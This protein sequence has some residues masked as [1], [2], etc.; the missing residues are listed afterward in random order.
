M[1][2]RAPL[3]PLGNLYSTPGALAVLSHEDIARA[4]TRHQF[5]DWG[6]VCPED[7][8]TNDESLQTGARLFSVYRG[9]ND[10]K[11]WIITE[12]DRS[13]TTVLLPEEY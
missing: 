3:F 11:F 8:Q 1:S 5:G 9:Q 4:I 13:A 10:A 2:S 12:S 6:D 7:K